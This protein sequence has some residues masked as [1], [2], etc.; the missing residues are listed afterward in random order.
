MRY[1]VE[2]KIDK[3]LIY[4]SP[5]YISKGYQVSELFTRDNN[6]FRRNIDSKCKFFYFNSLD[7]NIITLRNNLIKRLNL[8][9][10]N[11][12]IKEFF[13]WRFNNC[14]NDFFYCDIRDA[15]KVFTIEIQCY[16]NKFIRF[17]D[18]YIL[19]G[20]ID[21]SN[22]EDIIYKNW[23]FMKYASVLTVVDTDLIN[24]YDSI[25]ITP[26][27]A[28]KLIDVLN[29]CN[30]K[31]KD[32]FTIKKNIFDEFSGLLL[33]YMENIQSLDIRTGKGEIGCYFAQINKSKLDE[34]LYKKI[35]FDFN[36]KYCDNMQVIYFKD[37]KY[38]LINDL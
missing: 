24:S 20:F 32:S 31:I 29:K 25:L 12:R 23:F 30:L 18:K 17:E 33:Y 13:S 10:V 2:K 19:R 26:H 7:K 11:I 28:D 38:I 6:T 14:D 35:F 27:I 4:E 1:L 8:F 15:N 16:C 5:L 21:Y 3:I 37:K 22:I 34:I 9:I 36:E